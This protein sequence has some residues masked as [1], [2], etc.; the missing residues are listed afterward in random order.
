MG[1]KKNIPICNFSSESPCMCFGGWEALDSLETEME[2]RKRGFMLCWISLCDTQALKGSPCGLC[3]RALLQVK[4]DC[5]SE[6]K[7]LLR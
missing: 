7:A 3:Y 5:R 1:F 4:E 6:Q 2:Q